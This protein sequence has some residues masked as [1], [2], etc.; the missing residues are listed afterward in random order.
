MRKIS[1]FVCTA[2][3]I[4]ILA[5]CMEIVTPIGPS[6]GTV[7][8]SAAPSG[9]RQ[10]VGE[11][12]L[13]GVR[14]EGAAAEPYVGGDIRLV[15]VNEAAFVYRVAE[16][17]ETPQY[18][19]HDAAEGFS[20]VPADGRIRGTEGRNLVIAAVD[21][22]NRIERFGLF[23]YVTGAR[24]AQAE[25]G[26]QEYRITPEYQTLVQTVLNTGKTEFFYGAG[27]VRVNY[28][29][30]FG[31]EANVPEYYRGKYSA[32]ISVHMPANAPV[33]SP[34]DGTILELGSS[35]TSMNRIAV[36]NKELDMTLVLLHCSSI[37]PAAQLLAAGGEVRRGDLLGYAGTAGNPAGFDQ[38]YMELRAGENKDCLFVTES[39]AELRAQTYDPRILS[40]VYGEALTDAGKPT[41][42]VVGTTQWNA[43]NLGLFT[44]DNDTVYFANSADKDY[45]YKMNADGT[46]QQL[47][48]EVSAK[49]LNVV[50]GWLYFCNK[51]DGQRLYKMK[52]DGTELTALMPSNRY[53]V[54]FVTVVDDMIYFSCFTKRNRLSHIT[55]DG[56]NFTMETDGKTTAYVYY[57]DKLYLSNDY[58]YNRVYTMERIRGEEG[59]EFSVKQLTEYRAS[60]IAIIEDVIYF[61]NVKQGGKLYR[62]AMDGSNVEKAAEVSVQYLNYDKGYFYFANADEGGRLYRMKPDGSEKEPVSEYDNCSD[63]NIIGKWLYYTVNWSDIMQYRIDLE[64]GESVLIS[65]RDNAE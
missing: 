17:G 42:S 15:S 45:I 46:E 25:G 26:E 9:S 22:Q 30:A 53:K 8:A 61:A 10:P 58:K 56:K 51:S 4:C 16:E 34:M 48:A 65:Q 47:V 24:Y 62:M 29:Q 12:E 5:G 38:V 23:R 52:I 32:G 11:M 21:A 36:Y 6:E 1:I 19:Y 57:Q 37:A 60:S 14:L 41:F 50:E 59:D 27:Q 28:M 40:M 43:N 49:Y 3:C 54:E 55:T 33:Y 64:T 31:A 7:S 35:E 44:R 63:V 2:L 13:T 18:A 20:P 39:L